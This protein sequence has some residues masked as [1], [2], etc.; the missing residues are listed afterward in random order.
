MVECAHC[1]P[2]AEGK[3]PV[4]WSYNLG[5]HHRKKHA[6][7][8]LPA[9]AT[10]APLEKAF[11]QIVGGDRKALSAEQKR[12]LKEWE[13]QAVPSNASSGCSAS[14]CSCGTCPQSWAWAW[15]WSR[16]KPL[17]KPESGLKPQKKNR[18]GGL[19]PTHPPPHP[20][21]M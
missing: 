2:E 8:P 15:A 10:L 11:V 7:H 21:R 12:A 17:K 20:C 3:R 4:L 6:S 9:V 16:M 13:R 19:A 18:E 5:S 14:C 1:E